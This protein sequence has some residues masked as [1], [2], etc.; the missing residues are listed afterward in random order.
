MKEMHFDSSL[1]FARDLDSQDKLASCRERFVISDPDL[2]YFDGNSL[3]RLTKA[4]L[5]RARQ[6]VEEEWGRGLIRGWN[7]G[8]WEATSRV[9]D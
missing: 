9:G 4:S 8:W 7:Q 5:E 3:G 1:A 6:V 2:L